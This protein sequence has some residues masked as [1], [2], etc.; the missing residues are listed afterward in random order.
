MGELQYIGDGDVVTV[1]ANL[2][3]QGAHF[4]LAALGGNAFNKLIQRLG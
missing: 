1:L 2:G 4:Q 3:G